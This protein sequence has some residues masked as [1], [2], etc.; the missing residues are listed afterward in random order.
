VSFQHIIVNFIV[1]RDNWRINSHLST[2]MTLSNQ[3]KRNKMKLHKDARQLGVIVLG[4][5]IMVGLFH[6]FTY[7]YTTLVVRQARARGLYPTAE[8]GML[9]RIAENYEGI[10]RVTI[11]GAGPNAGV[12]PHVWYVTAEVRADKRADGHPLGDHNCDAPGSFFLQTHGGWF[13]V[14]EGA[15]PGMLGKWMLKYNLAG[16]GQSVPS[17]DLL[18][19]RPYRY[20]QYD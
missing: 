7:G 16:P 18:N 3:T 1:L 12:D 6:L 5:I 20:C 13:Y 10:K 17:T 14:P 9:Q 2:V 15:F 19:N 8:A 11:I 4:L